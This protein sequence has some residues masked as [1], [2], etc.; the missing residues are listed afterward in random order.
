MFVRET[1]FT[2]LAKQKIF[3]PN[4]ETG[5]DPSITLFESL[6]NRLARSNLLFQ[7]SPHSSPLSS[8]LPTSSLSPFHH[9]FVRFCAQHNIPFVLNAYLESYK[10]GITKESA[11]EIWNNLCNAENAAHLKDYD[12][13]RW[14]LLLRCHDTSTLFEASLVQAKKLLQV[15]STCSLLVCFLILMFLK[16]ASTPSVKDMLMSNQLFMALATLCYAPVS[17]E[18][19]AY[20]FITCNYSNFILQRH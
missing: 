6:L 18:G 12:W 3:L 1:T 9:F 2:E 20:I 14:M 17:L 5:S 10:L 15:L 13:V 8:V 4:L 19:R 16:A 7:H 11:D